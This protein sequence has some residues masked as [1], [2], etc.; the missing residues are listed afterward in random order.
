[1]P[2]QAQGVTAMPGGIPEQ[3][4]S[5][6]QDGVVAKSR[7]SRDAGA[8][9]FVNVRT[10]LSLTRRGRRPAPWPYSDRNLPA[11]VASLAGVSSSSRKPRFNVSLD[12]ARQSSAT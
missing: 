10:P 12:V 8:N 9:I 4:R 11:F 7:Q 6:P 1:M 2:L 3:A 5:A